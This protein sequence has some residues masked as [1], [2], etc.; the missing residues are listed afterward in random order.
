MLDLDGTATSAIHVPG[1]VARI[2]TI[3]K[4]VPVFL[5]FA[6]LAAF[7]AWRRASR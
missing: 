7:G 3:P 1:V 2:S 5:L 6:E 4:P